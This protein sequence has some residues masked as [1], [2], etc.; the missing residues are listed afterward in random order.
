M[1][2]LS[3]SPSPPLPLTC[4]SLSWSSRDTDFHRG[5]NRHRSRNFFIKKNQR[6]KGYPPRP[7]SS[8][9][10]MALPVAPT[11]CTL[12]H[13]VLVHGRGAW[14]RATGT[15]SPDCVFTVPQVCMTCEQLLVL[16]KN[17]KGYNEG[18]VTE[19]LVSHLL[20][21]LSLPP[22]LPTDWHSKGSQRW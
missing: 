21:A 5:L 4:T 9:S 18:L 3:S 17:E 7:V 1:S 13:S 11:L 15:L 14:P 16:G 2:P 10:P 20:W 19:A 22:Q 6:K 8:F 12:W